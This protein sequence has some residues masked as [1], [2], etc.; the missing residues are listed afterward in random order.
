MIA[1]GNIEEQNMSGDVLSGEILSGSILNSTQEQKEG[2]GQHGSADD[3]MFNDLEDLSTEVNNAPDSLIN[4]LHLFMEQGS[5]IFE[6]A[7]TENDKI[8]MKF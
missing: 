2:T 6:K 7:K 1:S 5:A 8:G 3:T 4:K